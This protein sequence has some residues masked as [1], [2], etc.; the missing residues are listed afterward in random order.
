MKQKPYSPS[1]VLEN[2]KLF[3]AELQNYQ[4]SLDS[5]PGW[6]RLISQSII[7]RG[8]KSDA[9]SALRQLAD[10]VSDLIRHM[11]SLPDDN[12]KCRILKTALNNRSGDLIN[13]AMLHARNALAPESL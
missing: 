12:E 6:V 4:P 2:L 5:G 10:A 11:D 9:E 13:D 7:Q 3:E 1:Q 8:I